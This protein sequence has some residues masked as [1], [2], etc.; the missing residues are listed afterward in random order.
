[1]GI[2]GVTW[3]GE[4]PASF[5]GKVPILLSA[6]RVFALALHRCGRLGRNR[7]LQ[8][9]AAHFQTQRM[10][11]LSGLRTF[12]FFRLRRGRPGRGYFLLRLLSIR[13]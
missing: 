13:V 9:L 4:Q 8:R 5:R 3:D 7:A 10:R 11:N 6:I 2:R 1:M 12:R